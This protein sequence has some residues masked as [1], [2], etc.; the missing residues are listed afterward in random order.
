MFMNCL[1]FLT[2]LTS[3]IPHPRTWFVTD[4]WLAVAV[5]AAICLAFFLLTFGLIESQKPGEAC[6][7]A[8]FGFCQQFILSSYPVPR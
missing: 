6:S 8:I 1:V 4:S 7:A 5:N 3:G 2:E